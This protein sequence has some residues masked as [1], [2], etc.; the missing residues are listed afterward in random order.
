MDIQTEEA[1]LAEFEGYVMESKAKIIE[2]TF[3]RP[4]DYCTWEIEIPG[5]SIF[6]YAV[7][8]R[9]R[10]LGLSSYE[11]FRDFLARAGK[12]ILEGEKV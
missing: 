5:G 11:I 12:V 10:E 4:P 6:R 2:R 7:A 1:W 8:L 3:E 9:A